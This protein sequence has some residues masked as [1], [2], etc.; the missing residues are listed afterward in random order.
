MS[1][2]ILSVSRPDVAL[3]VGSIARLDAHKDAGTIPAHV[4][5]AM[6]GDRLQPGPILGLTG[7]GA[8]RL[9]EQAAMLVGNLHLDLHEVHW[10]YDVYDAEGADRIRRLMADAVWRCR[11][12]HSIILDPGLQSRY[13]TAFHLD[14]ASHVERLPL[15]AAVDA[16]KM[17]FIGSIDRRVDFQW[18]DALASNEVSLA[19]F[20]SV[21]DVGASDTQRQVDLP[22]LANF[23]LDCCP[24]ASAI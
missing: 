11:C 21:H 13:P 20:R 2:L 17:V 14:N 15:V 4:V 23:A 1:L 16:S 3:G 24:I 9:D 5:E 7:L 6:I 10:L 19:I 12:Q 22:S 18:L 8:T